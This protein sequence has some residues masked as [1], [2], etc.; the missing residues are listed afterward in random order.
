MVVAPLSKKGSDGV[1]E[2]VDAMVSHDLLREDLESILEL[3]S[4]SGSKEPMGQI[5]SKVSTDW[6]NILPKH[7]CVLVSMFCVSPKFPLNFQYFFLA[8]HVFSQKVKKGE[9]Y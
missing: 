3:S 6:F 8:F 1:Q 2:A 5:E 9:C 4:W 7:F